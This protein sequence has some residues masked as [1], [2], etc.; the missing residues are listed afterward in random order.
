MPAAVNPTK[1]AYSI[2]TAA[3]ALDIS[4]GQI[5]RM[6]NAGYLKTITIGSDKRIPAEEIER[7]AREGCPRIPV[8]P[9]KR[10]ALV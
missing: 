1:R 5:Y 4:R 2:P 9:A 7:I 10:R 6:I 3:D 8:Q